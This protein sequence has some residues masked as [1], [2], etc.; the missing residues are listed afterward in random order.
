MSKAWPK[1]ERFALT[2][3]VKRSS[4]S[5]CANLVES[6]AKRRYPKH[7]LSKIT[8]SAGENAET[9]VWFDFA[10]DEGF[11]SAVQH[12]K[13]MAESVETGKLLTY[14]EHRPGQYAPRKK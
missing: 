3:Q 13:L 7:F 11:I 2:D 4:R 14:T 9:Q 6:F 5:V 1:H 8:D 12:Q 10:L